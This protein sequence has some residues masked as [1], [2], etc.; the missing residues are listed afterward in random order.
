MYEIFFVNFCVIILCPV[1]VYYNLKNLNPP[2]EKKLVFS[3][4][5]CPIGEVSHT[6]CVAYLTN[7]N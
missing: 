6:E 7:L 1:F 4:P 3:S 2:P 5:Q